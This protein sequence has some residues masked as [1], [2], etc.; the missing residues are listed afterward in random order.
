MTSQMTIAMGSDFCS[1][2]Y[3]AEKC[4]A[5][6]RTIRRLIRDGKL[7][8]L[9]PLIGSRETGRRHTLLFTAEVKAYADARALVVRPRE[10][11][12]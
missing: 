11:V 5:S 10:S 12:S 8:K 1:I 2:A 7:R 6:E 3:A 4:R 9:E